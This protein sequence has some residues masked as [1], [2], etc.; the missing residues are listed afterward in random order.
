MKGTALNFQKGNNDVLSD[1]N[2]NSTWYMDGICIGGTS[3][4]E[5]LTPVQAYQEFWH[6]W[7]TFHSATS[8]YN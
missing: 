7:R 4:E 8:R 5:R 2:T 1:Q 6:T 3:K